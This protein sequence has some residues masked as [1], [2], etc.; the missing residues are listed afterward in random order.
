DWALTNPFRALLAA[1]KLRAIAPMLL[2]VMLFHLGNHIYPTLWAF[3]ST[4][5]FNWSPSV[6]GVSL[7]AYGV[8][9]ALVQG[10]LVGP[11]VKRFGEWRIAVFGCIAGS[12]AALGFAA[13]SSAW[14]VFP[15]ICLAALSDLAPPA[16]TSRL[17][18][19]VAADAQGELQGVLSAITAL[20]AVLTP[21]LATGAFYLATHPTGPLNL[22]G[23]P[24]LITALLLAAATLTLRSIPPADR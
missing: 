22:P 8:M 12:A 20:T 19:R 14:L 1:F 16:L 4:A 2:V 13:V 7:A 24:F 15:L 18:Q 6:I 3:W 21:P 23:A 11:A 9:L 5:Q 17:S 10:A